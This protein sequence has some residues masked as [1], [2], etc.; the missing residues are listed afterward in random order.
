MSVTAVVASRPVSS[1]ATPRGVR[2]TSVIPA[3]VVGGADGAS[4]TRANAGA[5]RLVSS[6]DVTAPRAWR[7]HS[8]NVARGTPACAQYAAMLDRLFA[9]AASRRTRSAA[10]QRRPPPRRRRRPLRPATIEDDSLIRA[11]VPSAHAKITTSQLNAYG[12]PSIHHA[13][14][15]GRPLPPSLSLFLQPERIALELRAL[16]PLAHHRAPGRQNR[17]ADKRN[18]TVLARRPSAPSGDCVKRL[19]RSRGKRILP[20]IRCLI[21]RKSS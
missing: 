1:A 7:R 17:L 14:R 4:S 11:N 16:S 19:R 9:K 10:V 6:V 20:G 2:T 18:S 13:Y 3:G 8:I 5:A 15:A 12:R 21:D